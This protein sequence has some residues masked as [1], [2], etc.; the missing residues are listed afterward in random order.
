MGTTDLVWEPLRLV[1]TEAKRTEDQLRE[2]AGLQDAA[3]LDEMLLSVEKALTYAHTFLATSTIS[4]KAPFQSAITG[5]E[6]EFS[7]AGA[8]RNDV[9]SG[10]VD[11]TDYID[12]LYA[13]YN[14]IFDLASQMTQPGIGDKLGGALNDIKTPLAIGGAFII[15]VL[16]LVLAIFVM[17]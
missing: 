15:I 14:R 6:V 8:K 9:I 10:Q 7:E 2:W 1:F 17:K 4:D 12:G 13:L 5:M 11:Y 16:I 3:R